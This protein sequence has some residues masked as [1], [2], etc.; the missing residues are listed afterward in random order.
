LLGL[1]VKN[2]R[3]K[4]M[5]MEEFSI[6][7]IQGDRVALITRHSSKGL[8]FEVVIVPF[9]EDGSLPFYINFSNPK[10]MEEEKRVLFV[11]ISR[12]KNTCYLLMSKRINGYNKTLSRF[13]TD[14]DFDQI[15]D[16]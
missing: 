12:A 5:S 10:K 8:E 15:L 7:G 16:L 6:S 14:F 2:G 4:T 11:C 1:S 3:D 13:L 9:L